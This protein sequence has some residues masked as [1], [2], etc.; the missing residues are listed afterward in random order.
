MTNLK[1]DNQI[2]EIPENTWIPFQLE[3]FE[4]KLRLK[5]LKVSKNPEIPKIPFYDISGQFGFS[6][7]NS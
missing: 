6:K 1:R 2:P 5:N 3:S 7:R 4:M